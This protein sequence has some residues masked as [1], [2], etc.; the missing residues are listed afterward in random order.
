MAESGVECLNRVKTAQK[1][2]K[3]G[4]LKEK[5]H[6]DVKLREDLLTLGKTRRK[7]I[8][9]LSEFNKTN[10]HISSLDMSCLWYSIK[11]QTRG[12]PEVI[13]TQRHTTT[14]MPRHNTR[15]LLTL[16]PQTI[17]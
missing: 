5:K 8:C 12:V 1:S 4:K 10:I 13:C 6:D 3:E 16:S 14:C 11:C 2:K 9:V 17:P 7:Q 15:W